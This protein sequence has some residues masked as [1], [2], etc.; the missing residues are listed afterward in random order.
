M[1]SRSPVNSRSCTK[2]PSSKKARRA[3]TESDSDDSLKEEQRGIDVDLQGA[4]DEGPDSE[5]RER[6]VPSFALRRLFRQPSRTTASIPAAYACC[7]WWAQ[8]M[9]DAVADVW[10]QLFE[11]IGARAIK[12]DTFC[13]GF[14]SEFWACKIL[15][16]PVAPR[17]RVSETSV[18][19]R[20]VLR[21]NLASDIKHIFGSMKDQAAPQAYCNK[22]MRTC[23]ASTDDRAELLTGGTPCQPFSALTPKGCQEHNKYNVTFGE[24]GLQGDPQD[25]LM[26]LLER[27]LPYALLLEQVDGFGNFDKKMDERP[28]VRLLE[29]VLK[30]RNESGE[31]HFLA[32]KIFKMNTNVWLG[33][34]RPR[35]PSL[36]AALLVS[37]VGGPP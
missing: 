1:T 16:I 6:A 26:N 23:Y 3:V 14:G 4:C 35:S 17:S 12:L 37:F 27:T 20:E 25:S 21:L 31:Q 15:G 13:S 9:K 29:K 22:L 5:R 8:S 30:L 34:Q 36:H 10:E 28:L 2:P 33:M 11:G 18:E 24:T 19:M 7:Q 32:A